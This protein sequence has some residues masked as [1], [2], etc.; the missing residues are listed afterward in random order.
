MKPVLL[1]ALALALPA[2]LVSFKFISL[3]IYFSLYLFIYL[4]SLYFICL[5]LAD[6]CTYYNW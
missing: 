3:F 6:A 5:Y 4:C 1:V 2:V